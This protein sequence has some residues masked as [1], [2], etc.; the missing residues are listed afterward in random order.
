VIMVSSTDLLLGNLAH[1]NGYQHLKKSLGVS[2]DLHFH[3][4]GNSQPADVITMAGRRVPCVSVHDGEPGL[5][6]N[7]GSII[8]VKQEAL[9]VRH[10]S[11][12]GRP[13]EIYAY[14]GINSDSVFDACG[15]V[16]AETAL[17]KVSFPSHVVERAA[18]AHQSQDN[19]QSLWPQ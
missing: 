18:Q 4:N 10:H 6:D 9:A 16:L 19:W 12:S 2:G 13:V 8:G 17:E 14:H 3:M 15:K 1:E 5:L 11:K 7:I